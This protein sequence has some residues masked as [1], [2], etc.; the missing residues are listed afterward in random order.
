MSNPI[1]DLT[2][3]IRDRLEEMHKDLLK[4]I[5]ELEE[6]IQEQDVITE[7]CI[8]IMERIGLD[9]AQH[10]TDHQLE[11][12]AD[13]IE[14]AQ[15]ESYPRYFDRHTSIYVKMMKEKAGKTND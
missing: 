15:A 5:I 6:R 9:Y 14:Q 3:D 13:A 2:N 7:H 12:I 11:T 4:R 1:D 8:W 10:Y